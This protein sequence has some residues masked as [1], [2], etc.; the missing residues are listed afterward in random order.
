MRQLPP[1]KKR[2]IWT[3]S[4]VKLG[5]QSQEIIERAG[6]TRNCSEIFGH[7]RPR[8]TRSDSS[9]IGVEESFGQPWEQAESALA[10]V[11]AWVTERG[12]MLHPKAPVVSQFE[13][14]SEIQGCD[15]S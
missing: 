13:E 7:R 1:W 4:E 5:M 10:M 9:T 8:G 3:F 14:L 12:L 6:R 15:P 11:S 2:F